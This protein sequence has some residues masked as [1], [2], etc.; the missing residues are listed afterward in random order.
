MMI[1]RLWIGRN[2]KIFKN[3]NTTTQKLVGDKV[4]E[5]HRYPSKLEQLYMEHLARN[6]SGYRYLGETC[7]D[8]IVGCCALVA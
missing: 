4:I 6:G 5:D 1:G 2:D 8:G 7:Y 3:V